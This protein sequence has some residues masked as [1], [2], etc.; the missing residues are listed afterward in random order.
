M[1][2]SWLRCGAWE[3]WGGSYEEHRFRRLA[4]LQSVAQLP[5][6]WGETSSY[7]NPSFWGG[8]PG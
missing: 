1:G 4:L 6:T 5:L 3:R 7:S 2:A 8:P